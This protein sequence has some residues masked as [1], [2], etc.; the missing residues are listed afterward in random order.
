M[1]ELSFFNQ[2]CGRWSILLILFTPA[3]KMLVC[4]G[5]QAIE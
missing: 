4:M 5:K 3:C 1:L 2:N